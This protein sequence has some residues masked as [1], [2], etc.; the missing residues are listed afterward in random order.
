MGDKPIH[1]LLV[2]DNPDDATL[3]QITLNEGPRG[4]FELVHVERLEA[5]LKRL[6]EQTFDLVLLDLSLPDSRGLETF[7]KLHHQ[8]PGIPVVALTGLDDEMV[9]IT[10]AKEGAQDYLVKG[11]FNRGLLVRAMRY[12]IERQRAETELANYA[13]QLRLKNEQMQ[14]DLDLAREV[15]MAMLPQQFPTFPPGVAPKE[16]ALA[17]C[18]HYEPAASLGGDYY[19]VFA[20]SETAAGVLVCDVMGHGVR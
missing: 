10:A 5:A 11:Q 8:S 19:D 18:G 2:E 16:S 12:A 13:R 20:L 7:R 6:K 17:F 4:Q 14:A 3:L 15:Q 1:I 9:A